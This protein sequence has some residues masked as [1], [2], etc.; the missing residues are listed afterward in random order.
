M[1]SG[2]AVDHTQFSRLQNVRHIIEGWFRRALQGLDQTDA[3]CFEPFIF[4]WIAF[5]AWGESVTDLDRDKEWVFALSQDQRLSQAF[6]ERVAIQGDSVTIA[7]ERFRRYWPIPKVQDWRR[8]TQDRPAS[9]SNQDRLTFFEQHRISYEPACA[10]RHGQT[11]SIPLDWEHFIHATYRVRC[12]LFHGVKSP[13]D[14]DDQIIVASAFRA[15]V[16]FLE[17]QRIF[18]HSS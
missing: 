1:P 4:G 9:V 8:R 6:A 12:N 15:L 10:G 14:R 17:R 3:D 18:G 16:G 5:N 11:S 2:S 7:A 13:L